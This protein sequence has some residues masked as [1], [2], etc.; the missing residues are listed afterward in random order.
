MNAAVIAEALGGARRE[1]NGYRCRCPLASEHSR[2]DADPS[3]SVTDAADAMVLVHCHSRHA[4]E[5]DRVIDVL[6]AR[7]LW[8]ESNGYA[9]KPVKRSRLRGEDDYEIVVPVPV[10][11]PSA[12]ATA[13][14]IYAAKFNVSEALRFDYRNPTGELLFHVYRF[15]PVG[16]KEIR[17]MSL[18]LRKRTGDLVWRPKWPPAP[19]PLYGMERLSQRADLPVLLLEGEKKTDVAARLLGDHYLPLGLPSGAKAAHK[20]D[21]RSIADRRSILWPDNDADGFAAMVEVARK[22][23]S[24][25]IEAYGTIRHS[26]AVIQPETTW[27]SGH[28]IADLIAEGWDAT[29]LNDYILKRAIGVDAFDDEARKR[30]GK[31]KCAV[32]AALGIM[33]CDVKREAIRWLWDGY[34]PLGKLCDLQGDPGQ[35]KSLICADLAAR[36]SARL[37]LPDGATAVEGNV[38]IVSAEDDAAD[39][40]R[41]RL[42]AAGANLTRIRLITTNLP[43]LP[44]ELSK[45]R[46]TIDADKAVLLVLDPLDAFLS[47]KI[48]SHKN[49]SIRRLL[50]EL[51][52]LARETGTT[53]LT[54]RHLN[55]DSKTTNPMYRG[56]GSIGMN[57]AAR[58]VYLVGAVPDDPGHHAFAWVKGNL[59]KRP[60]TLGYQI[61][62]HDLGDM[63]VACIHWKGRLDLAA[64]D[65]LREPKTESRVPGMKPE[66]LSVAKKL[67]QDLLADGKEHPSEELDELAH[68][69]NIAHGTLMQAR[70]ELGVRARSK[71]FNPKKWFIWLP[72]NSDSS[73]GEAEKPNTD[74]DFAKS[75]SSAKTDDADSSGNSDSST[76]SRNSDSSGNPLGEKDF[77]N[78]DP[79]R[80]RVGN[81]IGNDLAEA[82]AGALRE[83]VGEPP[84]DADLF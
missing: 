29:R 77:D 11:A 82:D 70:R 53:I 36:I 37:Q 30:F 9:A 39:T 63:K 20:V 32:S 14:R 64:R 51:A 76:F 5:Q 18:F 13:G 25:Q 59:A 43:T 57:G 24:L 65:L 55:K 81:P 6:K 80:V 12:E 27:P 19:L 46:A 41:P 38:I 1:G 40:L 3:F 50:C 62:E 74:G 8:P 26:V 58:V 2:N 33:A 68:G 72:G 42:E 15:E 28:D 49:Q 16:G 4:N 56:G 66:K 60:A 61:E 48:D 75:R 35:G 22:V 52:A 69:G 17:P 54:V 23:E 31:G 21:L 10:G 45:L 79:R 78:L 84:E 7:G 67:I 44:D 47:D 34:L 83:T 73:G 71:G